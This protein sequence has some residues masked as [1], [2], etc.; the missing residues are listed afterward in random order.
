MDISTQIEGDVLQTLLDTFGME[1]QLLQTSGECG[2]LIAV[3]QNYLRAVK[4]KHRSETFADVIDKLVD[5]Y[6]MIQQIRHIDP[7]LFDETCKS[8]MIK[9]YRK[10]EDEGKMPNGDPV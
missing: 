8:K 5:V 6:F 2:K 1:E 9:V 3:I 7:E 4:F 10:L